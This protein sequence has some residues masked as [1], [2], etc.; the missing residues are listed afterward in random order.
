MEELHELQQA[1]Y[2]AQ[3]AFKLADSLLKQALEEHPM[4]VVTLLAK[5]HS[6]AFK[7]SNE[8][9]DAYQAALQAYQPGVVEPTAD[10][11]QVTMLIEPHSVA[12]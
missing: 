1:A 3:G 12:A 7:A 11:F 8:A 9:G 2:E 4:E 10:P 5:T 6:A